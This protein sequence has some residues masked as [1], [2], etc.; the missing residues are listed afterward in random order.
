MSNPIQHLF[1]RLTGGRRDVKRSPSPAQLRANEALI[2]GLRMADTE[3]VQSALE[4][5]AD[6]NIIDFS[7][8]LSA[9]FLATRNSHASVPGM[10]IHLLRAGADV[11]A[12]IGISHGQESIFR[13]MCQLSRDDI[14]QLMLAE[15]RFPINMVKPNAM[16][17]L[18]ETSGLNV[19]TLQAIQTVFERDHW[20]QK[21]LRRNHIWAT[22][23]GQD[24]CALMKFAKRH[25]ASASLQWVLGCAELDMKGRLESKDWLGR[26]PLWLAMEIGDVQNVAVLLSHG[27][28]IDVR[29]RDGESLIDCCGLLAVGKGMPS[30]VHRDILDLVESHQAVRRATEAM[31]SVLSAN[32]RSPARIEP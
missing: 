25:R 32:M 13:N 17:V 19:V 24:Q 14:V 9:L 10:V 7:A 1:H 21:G 2:Q 16:G 4:H 30:D 22:I 3:R 18:L 28:S 6:P 29:N 23:D 20:Q 8:L 15:S 27:A 5:G 12:P 11:N 26:T 31:E